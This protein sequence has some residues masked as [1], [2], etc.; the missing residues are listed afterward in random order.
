MGTQ[1]AIAEKIKSKKADYLLAVKENQKT[2][3]EEISL[4]FDDTEHLKKIK[5]KGNYHRTTEKITEV[6]T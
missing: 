5:D 4:Y 6:R 2:L 3:F 1:T